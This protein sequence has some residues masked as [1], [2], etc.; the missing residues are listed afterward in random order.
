MIDP[1]N[2]PESV[3]NKATWNGKPLSDPEVFEQACKEYD[4]YQANNKQKQKSDKSN[5]TIPTKQKADADSVPNSMK[6]LLKDSGFTFVKAGHGDPND[7]WES[8][9]TCIYPEKN[10]K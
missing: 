8:K 3:R 9:D 2:M 7:H 1:R 6:E 4:E 5:T 10:G